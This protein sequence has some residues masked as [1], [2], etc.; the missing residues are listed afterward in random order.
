[1]N[2]GVRTVSIKKSKERKKEKKKYD[3]KIIEEKK[4]KFALATYV[5][6]NACWNYRQLLIFLLL[7]SH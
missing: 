6:W 7:E 1:M 3:G 5:R 4:N 2:A